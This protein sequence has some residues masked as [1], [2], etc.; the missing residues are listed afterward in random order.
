MEFYKEDL[1]CFKDFF[2]SIDDSNSRKLKKDSPSELKITEI[3]FSEATYLTLKRNNQ[4]LKTESTRIALL[5]SCLQMIEKKDNSDDEGIIFI[6]NLGLN[7]GLSAIGTAI[8]IKAYY[9]SK[10]TFSISNTADCFKVY[11][12]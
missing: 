9:N 1:L 3:E 7:L 4:F 12:N 10:T 6:K 8:V 11:Q 5:Y 2:L